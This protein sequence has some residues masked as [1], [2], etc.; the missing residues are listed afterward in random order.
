MPPQLV[1]MS[2]TPTSTQPAS[3]VSGL[4]SGYIS[5]SFSTLKD[6]QTKAQQV[7]KQLDANGDGNQY[8]LLSNLPKAVRVQLDE[9]KNALNGVGFRFMFEGSVGVIKIVPSYVHNAITRHLSSSI[10]RLSIRNN[11]PDTELEWAMTTTSRSTVGTSGKQSD[12]CLLPRSRQGSAGQPPG[13]PTLV[14]E[15]GVS[16][17]FTRLHED[18]KWWFANSRGTSPLCDYSLHSARS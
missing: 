6:L 10:D 18:A 1:R 14:I 9:D 2:T 8:M 4:P 13:W 11:V 7:L 15:S 16:E 17:S 12:E 3:I 5:H